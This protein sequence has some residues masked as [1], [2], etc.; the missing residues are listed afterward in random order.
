MNGFCCEFVSLCT[1]DRSSYALGF[2]LRDLYKPVR[3]DKLRGAWIEQKK[4]EQETCIV[5]MRCPHQGLRGHSNDP[6]QTVLN[7][8]LSHPP[9]A[10]THSDPQ[11]ASTTHRTSSPRISPSLSTILVS[12]SSHKHLPMARTTSSQTHRSQRRPASSQTSQTSSAPPPLAETYMD[13]FPPGILNAP[14]MRYVPLPSDQEC[15][16]AQARAL[17]NGAQYGAYAQP[18]HGQHHRGMN[19]IAHPQVV[20]ASNGQPFLYA[21]GATPEQLYNFRQRDAF[22]DGEST[23]RRI[24]SLRSE[25]VHASGETTLGSH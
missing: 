10:C 3:G 2:L 1:P 15:D 4:H 16:E 13:N 21:Q 7:Q 6:P 19:L 11:L 23:F 24:R 18:Q 8:S 17:A 9:L 20:S 25:R 14:L 5:L 22:T 12:Y